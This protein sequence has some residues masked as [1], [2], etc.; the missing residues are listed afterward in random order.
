[1]VP[2]SGPAVERHCL[3]RLRISQKCQLDKPVGRQR[4]QPSS[5]YEHRAPLLEQLARSSGGNEKCL[6]MWSVSGGW[7]PAAQVRVRVR[8]YGICGEQSGT[9]AGSLRVL[10]FPLPIRITPI[11]PQSSESI[12]WGRY[13][14]PNSGRSTKWT[15]SHRMRKIC[16]WWDGHKMDP[17]NCVLRSDLIPCYV[18]LK[19]PKLICLRKRCCAEIK[20]L[21]GLFWTVLITKVS[22][23]F[24]NIT[25]GIV[26]DVVY[27]AVSEPTER[28]DKSLYAS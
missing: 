10:R 21:P 7:S 4:L 17:K 8:A 24:R 9:E 2:A 27:F 5:K 25:G 11:T 13:N 6:L 20:Y 26:Q 23:T 16:D 1:M 19:F 15:L 12:I 28:Q 3:K 18:V 22:V 14:R